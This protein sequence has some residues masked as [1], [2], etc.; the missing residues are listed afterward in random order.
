MKQLLKVLL[1]LALA[2]A[3]IAAVGQAKPRK[4][5][6][7]AWLGIYM[8][9]IDENLAEVFEL[10]EDY[11][12]VINEIIEDSPAEEAGLEED[13]IIIAIDGRKIFDSDDLVDLLEDAEEGDKIKLK[14]IRDDDQ[15]T[16]MVVLGEEPK[17]SFRRHFNWSSYPGCKNIWIYTDQPNS[18]IGVHLSDLSKQLGDYFGVKKGRGVLIT[19]V[20]EDSPAEEAGLQAGDIIVAI[21]KDKVNDT[22]DV[23]ELVGEAEPGEK[24]M[25]AVMR[26]KRSEKIEVTVGERENE[27]SFGHFDGSFRMPDIDIQIPNIDRSFRDH[28]LHNGDFFDQDELTSDL[29]E[30]RNE[31]KNLK[32]E[33]K[34]IEKKLD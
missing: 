16:I 24:I 15:K 21:D 10:D 29:E 7:G 8:Q 20:E 23:I 22:E 4:A 33:L 3:V 1:V 26:E 13:D 5:E 14:I 9:T 27:Y 28:Y 6:K 30:L 11:G 12:V 32:K 34:E 31:L 17:T 2:V 18:Y 19:E 25:V